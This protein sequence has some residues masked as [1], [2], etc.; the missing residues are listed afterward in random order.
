MAVPDISPYLLRDVDREIAHYREQIEKLKN[1][2]EKALL[3]ETASERAMAA[4]LAIMK[5]SGL[6][7]EDL[8]ESQRRPI[9]TWI[10]KKVGQQDT[11]WADLTSHFMLNSKALPGAV[12]KNRRKPN[13]APAKPKVTGQPSLEPGTYFNPYTKKT[14]TLCPDGDSD[15]FETVREWCQVFGF[16]TVESWR[17]KD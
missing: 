7:L 4:A 1:E 13:P 2:R 8:L 17:V 5:E 3:R 12:P 14:I 6:G 10:T 16:M 11:I 15:Q 9:R